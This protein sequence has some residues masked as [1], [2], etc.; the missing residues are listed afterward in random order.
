[1]TQLSPLT[2][3]Y[4]KA[5]FAMALQAKIYEK[6]FADVSAFR[7]MLFSNEEIKNILLNPTIPLPVKLNCLNAILKQ[8]NFAEFTGKVLQFLM[9]KKRLAILNELPDALNLLIKD[10]KGIV[11]VRVIT[12]LPASQ[13]TRELWQQRLQKILNKKVELFI[14][15]DKT[16]LGG[17]EIRIGDRSLDGTCR[18]KLEKLRYLLLMA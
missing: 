4:A 3:R 11:D 16:Q 2:L 7:D 17:I 12:A 14:K 10:Y 5:I 6:V 15:E 9:G 18:G 1:M 13:S 8:L